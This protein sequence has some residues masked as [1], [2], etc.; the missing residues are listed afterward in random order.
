MTQTQV[1]TEIFTHRLINQMQIPLK[2]HTSIT[3]LHVL[4][5]TWCIKQCILW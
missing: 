4:M 5:T 1:V 2:K 3:N